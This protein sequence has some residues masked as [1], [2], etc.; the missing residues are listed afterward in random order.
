[1]NTTDISVTP[2]SFLMGIEGAKGEVIGDYYLDSKWKKGTVI[3]YPTVFKE[4][5]DTAQ[6]FLIRLDL[7]NNV[8]EFNTEYGIKGV[9]GK[10]IQQFAWQET[11]A[12]T[13]IRFVNA[14]EFGSTGKAFFLQVLA[15]GKLT[16]LLQQKLWIKEPTY[17]AALDVGSKNTEIKKDKVYYVFKNG[18]LEKFKPNQG[19]LLKI[20]QNRKSSME[21]F[22]TNNKLDL[23]EPGDLAK[24]FEHYNGLE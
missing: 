18:K 23:D 15:E 6:G 19:N 5:V 9:P 2:S 14:K 12:A 1:M 24:V 20:M 17:N 10:D 21:K 3:F 13:P 7:K 22:L 16:L 11:E 8:L 4:K